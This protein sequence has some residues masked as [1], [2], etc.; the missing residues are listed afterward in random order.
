MNS[1]FN[2]TKTTESYVLVPAAY[3]HSLEK[4][5][6]QVICFIDA[7]HEPKG[8]WLTPKEAMSI[9]GC[10]ATKVKEL[11]YAGTLEHRFN[12]NNR[13]VMITRK[14]VEVFIRSQSTHLNSR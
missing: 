13:G 4:K 2:Q 3:L 10:S 12:G 8:K 5:L 11:K 14:S 1:D 9:I 6:D 7:N